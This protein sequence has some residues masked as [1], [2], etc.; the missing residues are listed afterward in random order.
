MNRSLPFAQ[1]ELPPGSPGEP[2]LVAQMAV[3]PS[4][5]ICSEAQAA[6]EHAGPDVAERLSRVDEGVPAPVQAE[7]GILHEVLGR[8]PVAGHHK[9]Q[10]DEAEGVRLVKRRDLLARLAGGLARLRHWVH[11]L[12]DEKTRERLPVSRAEV[13]WTTKDLYL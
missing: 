7:K 3:P 10:P 11:T 5:V 12:T 13:P 9:G 2:A 1:P 8:R 4:G 6:V